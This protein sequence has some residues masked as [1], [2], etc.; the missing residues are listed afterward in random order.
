M[1]YALLFT[2]LVYFFIA[3]SISLFFYIMKKKHNLWLV[4][5]IALIGAV[6]G[7]IIEVLFART[8]Q[9]LTNLLGVVNLF[10]P[11][12]TA[13]IIVSGFLAAY[14]KISRK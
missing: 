12:I 13:I 5:I 2:F 8:I 11:L 3:S 6:L 10:P 1:K 14:K 4:F 7:G 9:S